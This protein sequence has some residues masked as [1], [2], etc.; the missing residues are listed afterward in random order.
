MEDKPLAQNLAEYRKA[1]EQELHLATT[2]SAEEIADSARRD[3]AALL[4]EATSSLSQILRTGDKE[5]AVRLSACKLVFE[6]ALGKPA[7]MDK[8]ENEIADIIRQLQATPVPS[9]S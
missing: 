5:D 2:G 3:L 8:K 4:P 7:V 1:M 9:E 6:Y